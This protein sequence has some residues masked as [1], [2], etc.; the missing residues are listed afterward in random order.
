MDRSSSGVTIS[1]EIPPEDEVRPL[2]AEL[3]AG[4]D[5]LQDVATVRQVLVPH[6]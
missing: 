1:V 5:R 2:V 3:N 4:F 6:G